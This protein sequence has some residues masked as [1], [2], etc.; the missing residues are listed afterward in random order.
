M[1]L[2]AQELGCVYQAAL[3]AAL[4]QGRDLLIRKVD[5]S[6][7]E[8]RE[9]LL[10]D[11]SV[12]DLFLLMRAW[13]YASQNKFQLNACK[14]LG[15]HAQSARTV[16]P[17]LEHFLRIARARDWILNREWLKMPPSKNACC[18]GFRIALRLDWIAEPYA[19]SWCMDGV[20]TWREKV[21]FM[22]PRCL[23]RRRF[24]KLASTR[25]RSRPCFPLATEIDP[26]WLREYFPKDFESSVVVLW[27]PSMRRVVA[28]TQETFRGLM[29][30]AK[31]LEPPPEA[32]S[33]ALLAEKVQD[34]GISPQTM[35]SSSGT[36][37]SSSQLVGSN[38]PRIG[39]SRDG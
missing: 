5:R 9:E 32:Q 37:D 3:V 35:G 7:R 34:G 15:I 25:V 24:V 20:G 6:T 27:E 31:R 17:L 39:A 38:V 26:A 23:S 21:S 19:A 14:A 28:A 11:Q 1:L 36:V 4:T 33:A 13:S 18:W 10:G 16:K 8:H 22:V 2:A 30:S 29:L 12:S